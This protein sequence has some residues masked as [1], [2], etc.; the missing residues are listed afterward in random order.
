M[1]VASRSSSSSAAAG[2]AGAGP[3][4]EMLVAARSSS[5]PAPAPE[6]APAGTGGNAPGFDSL[7]DSLMDRAPL[8]LGRGAG[9][10]VWK[11]RAGLSKSVRRAGSR[12]GGLES[13]QPEL[14]QER[15]LGARLLQDQPGLAGLVLELTSRQRETPAAAPQLA[16]QVVQAHRM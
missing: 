6:G 2:S 1:L 15:S 11:E 8:P 9:P 10:P 13:R 12:R 5:R 16:L 7:S 4:P 3:L 14:A